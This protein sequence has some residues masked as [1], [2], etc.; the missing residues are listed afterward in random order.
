M[1][2]YAAFC[3]LSSRMIAGLFALQEEEGD[4]LPASLIECARMYSSEIEYSEENTE[5]ILAEFSFNI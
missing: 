5:E 1:R 4:V 2:C 3:V